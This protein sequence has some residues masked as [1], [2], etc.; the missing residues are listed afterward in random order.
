MEPTSE[1]PEAE[2]VS[3]ILFRGA[4]SQALAL[5]FTYPSRT[6]LAQ[7]KTRWSD[8]L[9]TALPWPEG[10][11]PLFEQVAHLLHATDGE[12]LE[13][14]HIRLFGP[15]GRCSLHETAYGDAG[16]LLG[17]AANL[18]DIAGFYLAFGLQPSSTDTHPEDHVTLEL[19]F[20]SVLA[21]KE[22]YA[23][24][25]GWLEHLEVTRDAQAK[26]VQ[27]HL[28][29]WIDAMA[30]QLHTT[31]PHEFYAVLGEALQRLVHAEVGR[32]RVSPVAVSGRP[33]DTEMGGETLQC[34][35]GASGDQVESAVPNA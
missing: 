10:V 14:E 31:H 26:F 34:P 22:A 19:E 7:L 1:N 32:L 21:L 11:R 27:D 16:R 30:E 33:A 20:M 6:V 12:A 5:G 4:V 13:R 28:G 9:N 24:V 3:A 8:L 17:K 15:A 2:R 29:T 23:L 25:E 18:A 35:R